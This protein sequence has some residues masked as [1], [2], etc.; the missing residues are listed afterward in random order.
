M[1]LS[2]ILTNLIIHVSD[3]SDV[4]RGRGVICILLQMCIVEYVYRYHVPQVRKE[5]NAF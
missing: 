3:P 1:L 2:L 5:L 4:M